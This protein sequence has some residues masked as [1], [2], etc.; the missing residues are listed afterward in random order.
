LPERVDKPHPADD[1]Q[2]ELMNRT[3]IEYWY[4]PKVRVGHEEKKR[5]I[6][7]M[8]LLQSLLSVSDTATLSFKNTITMVRYRNRNKYCQQ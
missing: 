2:R 5:C 3:L 8:Q 4:W 6:R 7:S 1:C